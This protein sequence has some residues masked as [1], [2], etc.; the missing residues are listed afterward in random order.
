[1]NSQ[2]EMRFVFE[3]VLIPVIYSAERPRSCTS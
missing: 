3:K 2:Y 1:M